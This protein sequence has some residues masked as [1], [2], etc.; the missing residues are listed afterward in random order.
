MAKDKR[1]FQGAQPPG[2]KQPRAERTPEELQRL[3]PTWRLGTLDLDGPFGWRTLDPARF[4]QVLQRLHAFESMN[5]NDI[6]IVGKKQNHT[7]AVRD[8]CSEARARLEELEQSD[9]DE[10]VSLRVT[11]AQRIWGIRDG[12]SLK[13]LWWDPEHRVCPSKGA[14]N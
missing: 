13:L 11:G 10:L 6:L 4:E 3:P 2:G 12:R 5:W 1:A 7:V 9:V 14:D 8:L